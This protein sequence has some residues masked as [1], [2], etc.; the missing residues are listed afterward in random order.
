[1]TVSVE[2]SANLSVAETLSASE[3]AHL[4]AWLSAG[5][6]AR[7]RDFGIELRNREPE[8]AALGEQLQKLAR[9]YDIEAL[10]RLLG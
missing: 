5:A 4:R 8:Q 1:M 3:L 2:P 9:A 7:I 10:R 6:L